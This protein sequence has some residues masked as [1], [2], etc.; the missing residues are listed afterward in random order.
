[1]LVVFMPN[2]GSGAGGLDG[3]KGWERW[4]E[5]VGKADVPDITR[6]RKAEG[7]Q[8]RGGRKGMERAP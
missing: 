1:M 3:T 4:N 2:T 5:R 7:K 8:V 6:R